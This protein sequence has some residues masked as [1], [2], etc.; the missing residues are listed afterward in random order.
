MLTL[1]WQFSPGLKK[2]KATTS[3]RNART[4][5]GSLS[6]WLAEAIPQQIPEVMR[7]SEGGINWTAFLENLSSK[8]GE[9]EKTLCFP[10]V[11]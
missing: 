11:D 5:N 9:S 7:R 2:L 8:D 6:S 4:G 1:K 3:Y 10:S